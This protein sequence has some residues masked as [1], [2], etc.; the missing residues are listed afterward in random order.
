MSTPGR[1]LQRQNEINGFWIG[2]LVGNAEN[3]VVL[4]ART[5]RLCAT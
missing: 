3:S 1:T 4:V 2:V 5:L